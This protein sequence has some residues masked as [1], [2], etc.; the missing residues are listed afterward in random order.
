MTLELS[1]L[2]RASLLALVGLSMAVM[3]DD[4]ARAQEFADILSSHEIE[5]LCCIVVERLNNLNGKISA[6]N[7]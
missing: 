5:A 4:R 1:E 3:R 7:N 2:E 6:G